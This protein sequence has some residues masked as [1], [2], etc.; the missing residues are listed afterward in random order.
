VVNA[1]VSHAFGRYA[2][3]MALTGGLIV[4]NDTESMRVYRSNV[5]VERTQ[6]VARVCLKILRVRPASKIREVVVGDAEG[7]TRSDANRQHAEEQHR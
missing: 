6:I 2:N 3:R 4:E 7:L 1:R 5:I